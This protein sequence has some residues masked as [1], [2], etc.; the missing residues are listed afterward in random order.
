MLKFIETEYLV[1]LA[2][3]SMGR[4]TVTY[5][6]LNYFR[7]SVINRTK[8]RGLN[9]MFLFGT[10]YLDRMADNYR[11][12]FLV[13]K[14]EYSV[15]SLVSHKTLIQRLVAYVPNEILKAVYDVP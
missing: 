13:D 2:M 8:N 10:N 1:A 4:K 15:R 3:V 11:E 12:L 7:S 9:V 14:E 6:E 5:G